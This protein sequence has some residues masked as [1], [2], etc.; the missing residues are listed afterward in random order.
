MNDSNGI[1][2]KM[3]HDDESI[4]RRLFIK[5]LKIIHM[6]C[7]ALNPVAKVNSRNKPAKMNCDDYCNDYCPTQ[8][9]ISN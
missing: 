5:L 2:L 6:W 4:A 1:E 9:M 7:G 8:Q 3:T